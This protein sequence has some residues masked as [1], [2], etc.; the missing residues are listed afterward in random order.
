M[1][2]RSV[3]LL[4][5]EKG[6]K[7]THEGIAQLLRYI[8]VSYH[9]FFVFFQLYLECFD[10]DEKIFLEKSSL[11]SIGITPI[12]IGALLQRAHYIMDKIYQ[13]LGADTFLADMENVVGLL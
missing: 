10:K 13:P 5:R 7:T 6:L 8:N 11:Y 2:F 3:A 12:G 4:M 9:S 1:L